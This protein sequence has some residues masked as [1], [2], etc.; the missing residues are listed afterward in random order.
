ML[1]SRLW[2]LVLLLLAPLAHGQA[3]ATFTATPSGPYTP[4]TVTLAWSTTGCATLAAAG[5]WTG[6][7]AASGT[8]TVTGVVG[9]TSYQ[10]TCTG[11]S[12]PGFAAL[13]WA[14]PTLNTDGSPL[15]NLAGYK[16]VY[17]TTAN[18]LT[19]SLSTMVPSA[20]SYRLTPLVDGTW[21]F[22]VRAVTT[23]NAIESANSNVTSKV[24]AATLGAV[25]G[26]SVAVTLD[27]QPNAPTGLT[28]DVVTGAVTSPVFKI[29]ADGSRSS[30]VAGLIPSGKPCYGTVAFTYRGKSWKHVDPADVLWWNTTASPQVAGAC[31]S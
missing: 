29:L 6:S 3:I 4:A 5:G 2:M 11:A 8:Q 23:G 9:V 18:A 1:C 21:Y 10:L 25:V 17:G 7:K 13:T 19:Q 24:V 14:P 20:T 12:T 27:T 31:R 22:A 15:T 26:K 30:A 16:I 28:V